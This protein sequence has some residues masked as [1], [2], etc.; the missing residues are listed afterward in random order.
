MPRCALHVKHNRCGS[1]SNTTGVAWFQRKLIWGP[2]EMVVGQM[3]CCA[4]VRSIPDKTDLGWRRMTGDGVEP[5]LECACSMPNNTDVGWQRTMIGGTDKPALGCVHVK[6]NRCGLAS[7]KR[8]WV[9]GRAN[10]CWHGPVPFQTKSRCG[11]A[12]KKMIGE[13]L[14]TG[15]EVTAHDG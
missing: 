13:R 14:R 5:V 2:T 12:S 8:W 11:L 6:Q 3:C 4:S 10:R 9:K 1:M 7:K 15:V